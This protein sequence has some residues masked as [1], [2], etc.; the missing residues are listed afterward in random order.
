MRPRSGN[1][2]YQRY[3]GPSEVTG[4]VPPRITGPARV[5]PLGDGDASHHVETM[6]ALEGH[7]GASWWTGIS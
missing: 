2:Y 7:I 5:L 6:T 3:G 1:P 4:S